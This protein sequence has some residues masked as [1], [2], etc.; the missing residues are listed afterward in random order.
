MILYRYLYT[1]FYLVLAPISAGGSLALTVLGASAT[2]GGAVSS[3]YVSF[4]THSDKLVRQAKKRENVLLKD[5]D[6]LEKLLIL[7][8]G[9]NQEADDDMG[10]KIN[11]NVQ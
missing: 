10:D 6:F 9:S 5:M 11:E 4:D 8:L 2:V 1:I 3:A 7:Y